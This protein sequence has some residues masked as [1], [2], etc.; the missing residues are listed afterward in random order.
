MGTTQNFFLLLSFF[1]TQR[2]LLLRYKKKRI[3][4]NAIT[5]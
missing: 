2:A 4:K 5:F 3:Y 1:N